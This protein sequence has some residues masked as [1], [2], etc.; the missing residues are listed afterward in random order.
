LSLADLLGVFGFLAL[1]AQSSFTAAIDRRS[2][3]RIS[4][5][6]LAASALRTC[7]MKVLIIEDVPSL[8]LTYKAY[9]SPIASEILLA[10]TGKD[11]LEV[12]L[13]ALPDVVVADVNLPDT[14]GIEVLRAIK[15]QQ[16]PVEIIVVTSNG[17][18]NLAVEAMREGAFDFV[19]KPMTADR[20]RVTV[21]NAAE[22]GTFARTVEAIKEQ[23]PDE[24]FCEFIGQSLPMQAVYQILRSAAQSKA[25]VFV[26]GESGTGK[27][28]CASA[29]HQLSPRAAKP[30][31]AINCA[32][33]PRELLES[34]IFGHVK[35]A[36][37][38]ATQDRMGAALLADGGTLFLDEIGEMELSFQAKLLRFLETG[39][40]QRVGETQ[41]KAT[42]VRIVCAT[43]RDPL[44]EVRTG[45]FREDLY[46]R[47]HVIPVQLPPLRERGGDI[48]LMAQHF[49]EMFA[50]EEG[51]SFGG[52]SI[53]AEE[54]LIAH[55]WPGNIRELKNL[56]RQI[57]VLSPGGIIDR[58]H[59]PFV[60]RTSI[61]QPLANPTAAPFGRIRGGCHGQSG[62]VALETQIEQAIDTAIAACGGSV[63]K[64]AAALKVSPSTIYRRLQSRVG[65]AEV[66]SA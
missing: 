18:I 2:L 39:F 59:L 23:F 27:E 53:E 57:V 15:A 10:S 56:I 19:V 32:A 54:T 40:V 62:I 12:A 33:I 30:F 38:G 31:V 26:T 5:S 41:P 52:F 3:M 50:R 24:R 14:T 48:V 8:A 28:L 45:R 44:A 6:C 21:R 16:L 9:L 11:G 34:E 37:T 13:S 1:V 36:F 29:L 49:L 65:A 63:P 22:R 64:A 51:K 60:N 4:G 35:G 43:N 58:R 66:Q 55:H 46:Y 47:L 20:L 42:D 25:T 7:P 17:S 61:V